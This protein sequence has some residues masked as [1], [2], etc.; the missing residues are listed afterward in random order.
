MLRLVASP[1]Q[2][3]IENGGLL[4]LNFLAKPVI[5]RLRGTPDGDR[6]WLLDPAG[7]WLLGD[8]P[9]QEWGF[10]L[11]MRRQ[12]RLEHLHPELH[13]V[14]QSAP[15]GPQTSH[16]RVADGVFSYQRYDPGAYTSGLLPGIKLYDAP[17]V[18]WT[19]ARW[20]PASEI[21]ARMAPFITQLTWIGAVLTL[22]ISLGSGHLA[23]LNRRRAEAMAAEREAAATLER[24]IESAPDGIIVSDTHGQIVLINKLAEQWLGYERGELLGRHVECLVPENVAGEHPELP[25]SYLTQ[26]A[27]RAMS[28]GHNLTIRR[29]DGSE[30][31]V[32][33]SVNTI[34]GSNGPRI[35]SAIRDIAPQLQVEAALRAS[36]AHIEQANREA[37]QANQ[38]LREANGELES[39]AYSVSH[40]LR[41][42]LRSVDGFSNILLKSYGDKLDDAGRDYL[43]RMR[44]AAQRMSQMIDDI[45]ILSRISRDELKR[46]PVDLSALAGEIARQLQE[47]TPQRAGEFIIAPGLS[48][49]ADPALVRV[50]LDNLLGNAWK[51]TGKTEFARIEFTSE[52]HDDETVF[53]VRDN[54]AGFDPAYADKLF[55]AFQRLH[56]ASDFPGNGIGLATVMRVVRKH[57]GRI[58]AEAAVGQ[59]ATFRFTLG[60]A[61]AGQAG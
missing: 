24:F 5:E 16:R 41:A 1:L 39:F 60:E 14:L 13:A 36:N 31:P 37:R 18:Y 26:P 53:V 35:I 10:M 61:D 52:Q 28:E 6:L 29:K 11:P 12:Y 51:Y 9:D 45:L 38:Q 55:G 22:L 44:A 4:V 57:G 33:I 3:R 43:Q 8:D 19:V 30:F 49:E 15:P 7:Y 54:G 58:W 56:H 25:Q 46:A 34:P 20:S 48:V 50:A 40:D 27:E 21:D 32:S 2:G 42:P 59:G 47:G 17:G 23:W